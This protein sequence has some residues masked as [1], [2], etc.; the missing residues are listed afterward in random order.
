MNPIAKRYINYD[1]EKLLSDYRLL[2]V[3]KEN[4]EDQLAEIS[5]LTAMNYDGISAVTNTVSNPTS[6]IAQQK[7]ELESR[8]NVH[9]ELLNALDRAIESLESDEREVIVQIYLSDNKNTEKAIQKLE[10][11][12]YKGRT[13]IFSIKKQALDKIRY[14][15]FD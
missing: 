4:L 9:A 2:L 7:I 5:E 8:I 13:T 10:R 11:S 12:L 14:Q 6:R 1:I 15:L 3:T